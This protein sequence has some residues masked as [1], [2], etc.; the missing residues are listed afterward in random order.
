MVLT[1]LSFL[2]AF[3]CCV[4]MIVPAVFIFHNVYEDGLFGR[5][6]LAAISFGAVVMLSAWMDAEGWDFPFYEVVPVLCFEMAATAL[7]LC[8]HLVRFHLRVV[9]RGECL[10][11]VEWLRD[12]TARMR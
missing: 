12:L 5:I 3:I 10:N 8:W 2:F 9:L 1:T 6:G 11:C 7:F 4:L